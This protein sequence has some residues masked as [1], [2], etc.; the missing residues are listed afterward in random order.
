[1]IH[2]LQKYKVY[3]EYIFTDYIRFFNLDRFFSI[4]SCYFSSKIPKN[5]LFQILTVSVFHSV[6]VSWW[7][8]NTFTSFVNG[9]YTELIGHAFLQ[10][11]YFE[12]GVIR[13]CWHD[14]DPIRL[15]FVQHFNNVMSNWSSTIALWWFPFQCH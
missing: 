9:T 5:S 4:A 8:R 15:I 1:M 2:D 3:M 6:A 11:R 13:R 10:V 7:R 14:F 12:F